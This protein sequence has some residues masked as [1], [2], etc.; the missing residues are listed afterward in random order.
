MFGP[1]ITVARLWKESPPEETFLVPGDSDTETEAERII[2]NDDTVLENSPLEEQ[3]KPSF[4]VSPAEVDELQ[5][6]LKEN[7]LAEYSYTEH[8]SPVTELLNKVQLFGLPPVSGVSVTIEI[9]FP[10]GNHEKSERIQVALQATVEVCIERFIEFHL[11]K[12]YANEQLLLLQLNPSCYVLK[13]HEKEGLPFDDLPALA[14]DKSI[15]SYCT[16]SS[17]DASLKFCLCKIS[18]ADNIDDKLRL[19]QIHHSLQKKSLTKSKNLE[20]ESSISEDKTSKNES[21]LMEI[22]L[23]P[24]D[25]STEVS[26]TETSTGLDLFKAILE[27]N[28]LPL[29]L[30]IYEFIVFEED[31]KYLQ[32]FSEIVAMETNIYSNLYVKGVNRLILKLKVFLDAPGAA[33]AHEKIENDNEEDEERGLKQNVKAKKRNKK[34]RPEQ[35]IF[36]DSTARK[37]EQWKVIKTNKWGKQQKRII[38]I[39]AQ[40]IY[41]LKRPKASKKVRGKTKNAER[42]IS[43]VTRVHLVNNRGSFRIIFSKQNIGGD[44]FEKVSVLDYF[45]EDGPEAAAKIVSKLRYIKKNMLS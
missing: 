29:F 40:K 39:D 20:K 24:N 22:V 35:Y 13:S 42:L 8:I 44:L 2:I 6:E 1:D 26:L 45:A 17:T 31:M 33:L 32:R 36:S 18:E 7:A 9:F 30:E 12:S 37:Y 34:I 43:D 21:F 38:G 4:F 25:V 16:A 5:F 10:F 41:N 11:R 19:K 3:P 14:S 27:G 15:E 28:K 23:K